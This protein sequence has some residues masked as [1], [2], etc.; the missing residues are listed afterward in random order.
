MKHHE[1]DSITVG[2]RAE[3]KARRDD[4][5]TASRRREAFG[6]ICEYVPCTQLR[7]QRERSNAVS[8]LAGGSS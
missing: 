6:E 3:A 1:G 2:R 8:P 4:A 5:T 7:A